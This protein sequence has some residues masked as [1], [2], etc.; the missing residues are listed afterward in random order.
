MPKSSTARWTPAAG[1]DSRMAM[2]DDGR[3]LRPL[4]T[5]AGCTVPGSA[6]SV[7]APHEESSHESLSLRRPRPRPPHPA[8]PGTPPRRGARDPP[9]HGHRGGPLV[10]DR[11]V[12]GHHVLRRPRPLRLP[13]RGVRALLPRQRAPARH[14]PERH[15][16]RGRDHRHDPRP[17]ARR[18]GRPAP[19]RSASSRRAAPAASATPCSPTAT[20]PPPPGAS[21]RPNVIKPETA[22]PAFDK[23]C[24]LF[25]IELRVAPVDPVTTLVDTDWVADAVDD[26]T[27][28][29]IGSACNYGY[30][31]VDP[32][33]ALS[34]IALEPRHRPPR[35]RLP[36][37]VD[38]PLRPGARLRHPAVRLPGA[39]GHLDLG[40]HPQV[41]LRPEGHLGALLPGQGA[42][43]RPVL[44]PHR[45]ERRQVLLAGHGRLALGRPAGRHLGVDGPARSRGLPGLRR[46]DLRHLGGHA[47]RGPHATPSC[48]S[49]ATRRSCSASPP[50]CSTS[51]TSTTSCGSGAGASTAS[52]TRTRCTWP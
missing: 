50:T 29:L 13:E 15:P 44:L 47:G 2:A 20:T 37:R 11:Q 45:L 51:T 6:T 4:P 35:R 27:V 41:R 33:E 24:H 40:R 17:P 36:R 26:Q 22:H 14:V 38:P 49:S 39:R 9:V 21:T 42:A 10:G 18:G 23:A 5:R 32:I 1:N 16:V 25:G 19:S 7:A 34:D 30:G 31:T 43:Q 3:T 46:A 28:A 48:A 12:L 52:S 8:R